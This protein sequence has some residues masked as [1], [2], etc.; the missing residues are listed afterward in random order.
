M[1]IVQVYYSYIHIMVFCHFSSY[2]GS[3]L[4]KKDAAFFFFSHREKSLPRTLRFLALFD[5]HVRKVV[6]YNH[7]SLTNE[8]E[9]A[10]FREGWERT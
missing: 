3:L 4:C 8:T 6:F 9:S 7:I 5:A 1:T 10:S 2:V